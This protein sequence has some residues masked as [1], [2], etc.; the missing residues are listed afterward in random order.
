M[1]DPDGRSVEHRTEVNS[2]AGTSWVVTPGGINH[3]HIG[4]VREGREG[5]G[6][7][8]SLAQREQP[9]LVGRPG[10]AGHDAAADQ[11]SSVDESSTDPGAVPRMTWALLAPNEGDEC[12]RHE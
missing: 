11:S 3:E 10:D 2:K 6:E 9:G 8:G 12:C 1:G 5:V 7:H 4:M